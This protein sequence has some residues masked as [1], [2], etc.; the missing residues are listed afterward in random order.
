MNLSLPTKS[1]LMKIKDSINLSV[2]GQDLLEKKKYIL[3]QEKEKYEQKAK[4]LREKLEKME[5]QASLYL[6][7]TNVDIGIEEVNYIARGIDID[8]GIDIKYV[9]VMGVE[10]PS[11]IY[12]EQDKQ[13]N[14]GIVNTPMSLDKAID[15]FNELKSILIELA[16]LE[17]T[18][19]ILSSNI[20]KVQKRSNAL[21]DIIIPRDRKIE[22]QISEVLDEREREEFSRLKVVKSR[23]EKK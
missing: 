3:M 12:E 18:I 9:T 8:D 20:S 23:L 1:N 15:K 7:Q 5:E 19:R 22:A 11:I 21:K 6:R 17:N 14:Y 2:Q 4:E 13:M 10:I 16:G